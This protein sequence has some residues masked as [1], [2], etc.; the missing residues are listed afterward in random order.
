M[1]TRRVA[2]GAQYVFVLQYFS[3]YWVH[4]VT[5]AVANIAQVLDGWPDFK[6]QI[7]TMNG[8]GLYEWDYMLKI[9]NKNPKQNNTK[10]IDK[11]M[12]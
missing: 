3:V 5:H 12:L 11:S 1:Q 8:T 6:N 4:T 10:T 2:V 7:W 9:L